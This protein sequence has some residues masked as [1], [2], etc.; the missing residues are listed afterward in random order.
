MT[1]RRWRIAAAGAAVVGAAVAAL[2][3]LPG[4]EAVTAVSPPL[5]CRVAQVVDEAG[6]AVFG[7]EDMVLDARAGRLILSAYDRKAVDAARAAGAPLPQGGLFTVPLGDLGADRVTARRLRVAGGGDIAWFPHG[8]GMADDEAGRRLLVINRIFDGDGDGQAD[9]AD[10]DLLIVALGPQPGGEE[11][12]L[13]QRVQSGALCRANDADF[14]GPETV[15]VTVDHAS[16]PLFDAWVERVFSRPRSGLVRVDLGDAPAVRKVT[17]G[18]AY[19]NGIEIDHDLGLVHVAASRGH[20]VLTFA[21]ADV[22]GGSGGLPLRRTPVPGGPDNLVLGR[23]GALYTAAHPD[24]FAL[25]L[26]INGL[27]GVPA[28]TAVRIA[29]DGGVSVLAGRDAALPGGATT[30]LM[31]GGKL[32]V[33]SAWDSGLGICGLGEGGGDHD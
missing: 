29:P 11:A 20:E 2:A 16:C 30:A 32:V 27:A 5:H 21:L 17:G 8:I 18:I 31:A 13:R 12:V 4:R 24:L 23:D 22:L 14:A 26:H 15:L 3:L 1:Q 25:F 19:A 7:I 6:R 9:G 33:S 10:A 28:S